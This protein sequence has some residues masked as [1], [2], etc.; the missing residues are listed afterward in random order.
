MPSITPSG[1]TLEIFAQILDYPT[2]GTV[3]SARECQKLLAAVSP[4][5]AT[6]MSEFVRSASRTSL[7]RLEEIY[8]SNFDLAS[9]Y[10]PYL[11]Y[12]LFGE[13]YGRSLFLLALK[14][15]YRACGF[16]ASG[17]D[18]PDRLST[19]LRFLAFNTDESLNQETI[20]EGMLP[21]LEKMM[22]EV[23][24]DNTRARGGQSAYLHVLKGLK[25][26]LES[27]LPAPEPAGISQ[28]RELQ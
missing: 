24:E 14:T 11:G 12:H 20:R 1:R 9:S 10:H 15:R 6:Q 2:E 21:A 3:Q 16:V 7:E 19:L 26:F 23:P 5:A 25:M 17:P 18:L 8:T 28:G 22:N 27:M 13:T 4:E